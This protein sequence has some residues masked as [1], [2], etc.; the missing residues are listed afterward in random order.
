MMWTYQRIVPILAE[1]TGYG[2][3]TDAYHITAP[4]PE[5]RGARRAIMNALADAELRPSAI[6][7]I[8]AHGTST[9]LNDY[10]ETIAIKQVFGPESVDVPV[11]SIKSMTGHMLG[12]AGAAELISSVLTIQNELIPPTINYEEADEGMDLNYVPHKAQKRKVEHVLSNSFGFG[13]HNAC[14]VIKKWRQRGE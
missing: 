6:D 7:Y 5:A 1:L 8:N 11:S 4:D 10:T 9:K 3:T 14:L 12:G 2:A 13:G